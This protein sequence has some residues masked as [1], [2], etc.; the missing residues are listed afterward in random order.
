MS[1]QEHSQ[2]C[3]S[4]ALSL[5]QGAE[6]AHPA[7][8]FLGNHR[9]SKKSVVAPKGNRP[10]SLYPKDTWFQDLLQSVGKGAPQSTEGLLSQWLTELASS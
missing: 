7:L 3:A 5:A 8:A 2:S 10:N 6:A 4:S 9:P 1:E